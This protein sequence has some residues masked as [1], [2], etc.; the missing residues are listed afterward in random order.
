MRTV[1]PRVRIVVADD[2]PLFR[3]ALEQTIRDQGDFQLVGQASDGGEAM[4]LIRELAPNVAVLDVRMPVLDGLQVVNAVC[5]DGLS[6]RVI[7]L[8][9][10]VD[11]SVAFDAVAVGA[12]AYLSKS[13]D[14]QLLTDTIRAVSR[15]ETVLGSEVQASLAAE[16]RLRGAQERPTLS[17]RELEIL[18][19]VAEG[20][21]APQIAQLLFLS[22][23]TIKSH[24]QGLYEKLGV[25]DRAAAVAEGMR[26][27]LLE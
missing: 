13:V 17:K 24:L 16:I 23:P 5:R 2:H 15:G 26:R 20:R 8:S 1:G 27:R 7:L 4:E 10:Y 12:S 14:P 25:S 9:A 6:T 11:G 18:V 21:S 19:H 22:T 3:R